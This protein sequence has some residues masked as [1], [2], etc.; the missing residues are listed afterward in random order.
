MNGIRLF[1]TDL[2]GTLL[3]NNESTARFKMV[4]EGLDVETRPL[5]V[6]NSGRYITDIKD[7]IRN[8]ELPRPDF[9]IASLGTYIYDYRRQAPLREFN[10]QFKGTW[11][12][13]RIEEILAVLPSVE[14]LAPEFIHPY[15]SSWQIKSGDE[16][17]LNRIHTLL[18]ESGI[19][20]EV[21]YENG[22]NLDILPKGASKGYSLEWLCNKLNLGTEAVVV[23]GD[24]GNDRSMFM[25]EG[26]RGILPEN[27]QPELLEATLDVPSIAT[28]AILADGVLQGLKHYE[29]IDHIPSVSAGG[30][31]N[32][33]I[34]PALKMLFEGSSLQ[35]LKPRELDL[36]IIG[37]QKAVDALEK[38]ITPMGYSACSLEDNEYNGTDENYR[39][40]W[41]RD[42]SIT[43]ISS[44]S[45]DLPDHFRE[46]E[47]NT[48]TTLLDHVSPNGQIPSNVRIDTGEPDYSGVGRIASIDSVLWVII[49]VYHYSVKTG[50]HDI[51]HRYAGTL[52]RAMDWLSANDSNNDGLLEI[53]EAGDW[54]DLFGRS[55]NVLYDEV[56]WCRT[57][58]CYG[59]ILEILGDTQR[60]SD[61]LKWSQHIRGEIISNFWPSTSRAPGDTFHFSEQQFTVGDTQYLLA[62]TSPFSFDWRCDVY[63]NILAFLCNVL[64]IDRAKTAFKFMWGVGVNSPWPVSNL[65]PVVQS[66]DPDWKDYYTVN[67][68]NLPGHYHNGGIWPFIGGMWVR[69]I[70]RLGLSDIAAHEL[71][72]LAE[73]CKLGMSAEWEFNEW[74]HGT[75]GRPLG[76]R[77]QAWS[78]SSFIRACNEME[79]DPTH[80]DQD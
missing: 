44:L 15:K 29:I 47:K 30:D 72:R 21:T 10:D 50:D 19:E 79:M 74:H 56:L 33:T 25:L 7:L 6:Y 5:L 78:A 4:W 60:A 52:Q 11:D 67:L 69:F 34:D 55:Y 40:V 37:Y 46:C 45:A 22:A 12:S 2:D 73:M 64:D 65:Y 54:T 68:L 76:K 28:A 42:G 71:V 53:P 58:I 70:H 27:A 1:A 24:S 3:G 39:S 80:I 62:Q 31:S 57:N 14:K 77:Y 16:E 9:I 17:A 49:A 26:V 32:K 43:L 35:T 41:A 61:Y 18:E 51:L 36:I 23:A 75:T 63:A 38:C 8:G 48:L 13:A 20:A 66:G 59:K